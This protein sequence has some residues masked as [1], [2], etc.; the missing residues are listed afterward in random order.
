[1][2]TA[3]E[4]R[5]S[6]PQSLPVNWPR[7]LAYVALTIYAIYAASTMGITLDRL[8]RGMTQGAQFLSRMWPPNLQASKLELMSQGLIESIEIAVLATA[9]GVAL[10]LP[11]GLLAA[12]NL[13]PGWVSWTARG[14]IAC[15]PPPA[16]W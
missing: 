12:R 5:L 11:I 10:S 7:R 8:S 14:A 15:H 13:M 6:I 9:A 3:R 2:S 16:P 4:Q 1:M